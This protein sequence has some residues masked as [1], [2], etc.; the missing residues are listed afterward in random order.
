[1]ENYITFPEFLQTLPEK[2]RVPFLVNLI[3]D[4]N[5][6]ELLS[7]VRSKSPD[8]DFIGEAFKWD[9]TPEGET[10]WR[11]EYEKYREKY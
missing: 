5:K 10:V 7:F 1:M 4:N 2:L 9:K 8:V 11:S 6:D 3:N